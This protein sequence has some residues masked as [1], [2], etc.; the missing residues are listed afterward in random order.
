MII[1]RQKIRL[2]L[3]L[4]IFWLALCGEISVTLIGLGLFASA[5]SVYLSD[6]LMK[7]SGINP[8]PPL[9]RI[10][11]FHYLGLLIQF[12]VRNTY[13]H[14]KRLGPINEDVSY[15]S[16][17]LTVKHPVSRL[18]IANAI[19]LS[20]GMM[21]VTIEKN[22]LQVICYTSDTRPDNKLLLSYLNRLE[23]VFKEVTP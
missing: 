2:F 5:C 1:N 15:L 22:L 20:P 9:P 21:S 3:M 16:Y 19:T 8:F 10:N 7:T 23:T 6:K 4:F 13:L 11:W 12:M 18:L 14:I 17:E